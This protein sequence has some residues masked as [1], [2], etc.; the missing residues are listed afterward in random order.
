M[1]LVTLLFIRATHISVFKLMILLV[2]MAGILLLFLRYSLHITELMPPML[3]RMSHQLMLA[4]RIRL[5]N[6]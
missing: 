1:K 2:T 3:Y 5:A 4:M 6:G